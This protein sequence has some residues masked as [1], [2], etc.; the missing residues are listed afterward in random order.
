MIPEKNLPLL[1]NLAYVGYN[2][3]LPAPN[4]IRGDLEPVFNPDGSLQTS[5]CNQF[6]QYICN[7]LGYTEFSG[8]NANEMFALM[9]DPK[10][11]WISVDGSVAQDHANNGVLVLASE[12]NPDGHGHVCLVLPGILE[13][14]FAYAKAVPKCANVGKDV[15]FGRKIS[16]AF[17]Q[18]P[19]YFALAGMV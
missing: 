13:K 9:S 16:F 15:F 10:N 6:V 4:G 5:Y 17:S 2:R 11:G 3:G 8:M 7:G 1:L 14:S 12:S 18:P 19:T